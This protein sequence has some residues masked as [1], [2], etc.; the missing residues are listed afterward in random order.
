M[1]VHNDE[2]IRGFLEKLNVLARSMTVQDIEDMISWKVMGSGRE[3]VT[4]KTISSVEI[5]KM[6]SSPH[7]KVFHRIAKYVGS[8]ASAED[9]GE[10][11]LTTFRNVQEKE[12]PMWELTERGCRIYIDSMSEKTRYTNIAEGVGRLEEEMGR[13]FGRD[14]PEVEGEFLLENA[15]KEDYEKIRDI[16]NMFITG[17]AAEGREIPEL[18]EGYQGFYSALDDVGVNS[19]E[20]NKISTAVYRVAIEAEMQGFIYGFKLFDKLLSRSLV[21]G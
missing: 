3:V 5:A 8:Y 13:R 15:R 10:F 4:G 12:F 16:F 17:P 14:S 21:M 7:A 6:F 2:A 18:T 11:C 19:R 9:K 1:T 20:H